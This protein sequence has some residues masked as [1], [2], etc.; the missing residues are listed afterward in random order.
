[1]TRET[2]P[3][4]AV[5]RYL[6]VDVEAELS[7]LSA[8]LTTPELFLDITSMLNADDF[9]VSNHQDIYRAALLCDQNGQPVDAITIADTLRRTKKLVKI[10][11]Q[12]TID[13]LI[14]R[15]G[16]VDNVMHHAAIVLDKSKLRKLLTVGRS[17]AG[18]AISPEAEASKVL[19]EAESQVF[20]L[21]KERTGGSMLDMNQAV[22]LL[23][24][25][26]AKAQSSSLVGVSTGMHGLDKITGGLQGGQLV[27]LAARPAMGKSALGVQIA[28][29]IGS[30]L[31]M[32]QAVPLLLDSLAKAQSSSLVGVSTGMHGLDKITGGLQGGQLVI[33]AARPAMGKSALGV[34][35]ARHIAETT[36]SYVPVLSYEMGTVEIATRMLATATGCDLLRLKGGDLPEG[37]ER[38]IAVAANELR[39]LSVL[40]DDSPPETI[41]GVRSAMRRLAR[42]GPIG[43]I[44]I[45]YLQLMSG[46]TRF[47]QD[48]RNQE[49]SE[50]SRGL[51]RLATELNVPIIAL[52]QLNRQLEQRQN[53]RPGLSDLRESGSLEQDANIVLFLYREHVYNPSVHPEKTELIVAKQRNGPLG[54]IRLRFEGSCTR[55]SEDSTPFAYTGGGNLF[56]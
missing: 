29:H 43:A 24:D 8:L 19:A 39:S 3:K 2:D 40:I 49:V 26:L 52:S 47:M 15:G 18:S 32:N 48:S 11:G 33:L 34:Q 51:K 28:R 16:A 25:S 50:I 35:I 23:L 21:G 13:T 22:P 42:R 6:P 44:V 54:T 36:Q 10:G 20:Q 7:V 27:I 45:D 55:F 38:K 56:R 31:D 12:K 46:E 1:M 37:M 53:K 41:G 4:S 5:P 30:M 17:I 14:E 9:G